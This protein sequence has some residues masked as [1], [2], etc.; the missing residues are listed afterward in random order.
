MKVVIDVKNNRVITLL[1]MEEFFCFVDW[2]HGHVHAKSA[3]GVGIHGRNDN[4]WVSLASDEPRD[5]FKCG[6]CIFVGSR[7]NWEGNEDLVG[8]KSGV[9]ASEIVGFESADRLDDRGRDEVDVVVDS[10]EGFESI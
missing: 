9:F 4:T 8:V 6:F 10:R 5:R 3:E 2:L 1:F 7:A